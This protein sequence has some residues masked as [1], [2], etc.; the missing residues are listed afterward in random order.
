MTAS[1]TK[2]ISFGSR[3]ENFCSDNEAPTIAFAATLTSEFPI[4]FEMKG[5]VLEAL[6]FTSKI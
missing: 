5:T 6:G 4:H 3:F 2:N 1:L